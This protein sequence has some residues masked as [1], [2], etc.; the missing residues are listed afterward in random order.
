MED[1][2]ITVEEATTLREN[3]KKSEEKEEQRGEYLVE[4][5]WKWI[6]RLESNGVLE[7]E[8]QEKIGEYK[9]QIEASEEENPELRAKLIVAQKV[10]QHY[11]DGGLDTAEVTVQPTGITGYNDGKVI[12]QDG[13]AKVALDF[14]SERNT[15]M[16]VDAILS[17]NGLED[18][19]AEIGK[20]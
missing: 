11:F 9:E 17:C 16:A 1:R 12:F 15:R 7:S 10:N 18:K 5:G 20:R 2:C 19:G 6:D 13:T 14:E 4:Y 8:L 3:V